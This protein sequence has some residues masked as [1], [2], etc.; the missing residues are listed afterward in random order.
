LIILDHDAGW[1]F[2]GIRGRFKALQH[3]RFIVKEWELSDCEVSF[4]DMNVRVKDQRLEFSV[5]WKPT[6][7]GV[8]LGMHSAHNHNTLIAWKRGEI[9]RVASVSST[10]SLF[11]EGIKMFMNRLKRY[12]EPV[13]NL[14]A[15]AKFDPYTDLAVK[16]CFRLTFEGPTRSIRPPTAW[17]VLPYHWIWKGRLFFQQ[18]FGDD[19][20]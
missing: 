7:L 12:M 9:R 6:S 10:R 1:S 11:M 19:D 2:F 13:L 5:R 8:P 20:G 14:K 17:L 16:K 15:L 18:H 4:L 3:T